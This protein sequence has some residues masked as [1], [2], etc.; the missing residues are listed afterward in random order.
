MLSLKTDNNPHFH[1]KTMS[2]RKPTITVTLD[3]DILQWLDDYIKNDKSAR[4]ADRSHAIKVAL[5]D[6]RER[7]S[8]K[9]P[10][11]RAG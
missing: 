7:L 2:K 8:E 4:F 10:R 11:A 1:Y 9:T 5:M 6:M 3:P